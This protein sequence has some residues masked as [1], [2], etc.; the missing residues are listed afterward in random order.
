M[1]ASKSQAL[2]RFSPTALLGVPV[3]AAFLRP[4]GQ[5]IEHFHVSAA[6]AGAAITAVVGGGW[7]V[8][9]LFPWIIPVEAT[10]TSLVAVFGTAA[11]I[12]W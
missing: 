1:N 6:V 7:Q 9:V 11:A 3:A 2:H 8:A 4:T 5:V 12:A 10:I